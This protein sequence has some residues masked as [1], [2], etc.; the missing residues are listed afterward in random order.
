MENIIN[1]QNFLELAADSIP[2]ANG[3]EVFETVLAHNGTVIERIISNGQT[4]PDNEWYDQDEDEWVMLL[5]GTATLIFFE[6]PNKEVRLKA[7]DYLL[8]KAR[9]KHRVTYTSSAPVC[10]WLALFYKK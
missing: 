8:I 5:Q 4:T 10:V 7:G 3:N 1:P 2:S 9:Q 6:E